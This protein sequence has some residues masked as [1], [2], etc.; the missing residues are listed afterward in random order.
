MYIISTFEFLIRVLSEFVSAAFFCVFDCML[1][2][3]V[4]TVT[5]TYVTLL[6]CFIFPITFLYFII[7]VNSKL[8]VKVTLNHTSVLVG[9][10]HVIT[11]AVFHGVNGG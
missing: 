4:P 3:K 9:A 6:S 10:M 2:Y 1:M 11:G 8:V 5:N 7:L